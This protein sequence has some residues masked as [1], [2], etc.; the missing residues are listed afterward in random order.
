[1]SWLKSNSLSLPSIDRII[2]PFLTTVAAVATVILVE[3]CR[4]GRIGLA[5]NDPQLGLPGRHEVNNL[6]I[7]RR[8]QHTGKS[9]TDEPRKSG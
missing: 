3:V 9:R 2:A 8:F 6:I 4:H 1:M 5:G 7:V